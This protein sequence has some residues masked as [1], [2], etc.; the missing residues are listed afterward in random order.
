VLPTDGPQ[1]HLAP[2]PSVALGS[3]SF[4]ASRFRVGVAEIVERLRPGI[5]EGTMDNLIYLIGLIVVVMF[6]LSFLGIHF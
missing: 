2:P 6:V 3:T 5:L 1:G 4:A